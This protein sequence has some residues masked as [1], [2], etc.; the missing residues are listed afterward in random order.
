[1]PAALR[2]LLIVL[3]TLVV[4]CGI[5]WAAVAILLPPS[6]VRAL[7]EQQANA[8]L[9]RPFRLD[10]VSVG[11]WPPVRASLRG[12]A[13]AEPGGFAS[14]AAFQ[15]EAIHVDVDLFALIAKRVVVRRLTLE[16][17]AIH[18]VLRADGATNFDSL[19]KAP[20]PATGGAGGA[21]P[22]PAMDLAVDR[23]GIHGGQLLV[24]DLK[25]KRRTALDIESTQHLSL[26]SN[27][28]RIG[29]GG[30][31]ALSGLAFG[32]LTAARRSD[33]NQ[34]LAA[35][36]W[37]I[38]HQGAY[39]A[40][41]QRLALERLALA[42]GGT[43][44]EMKGVVDHPGP[45]ATL[46]LTSQG[47]GVDLAE[48]LKMLATADASALH[49]ISGAGRLDF[50][51]RV[52][53]GL[54]PDRLPALTGVLHLKDASFRYPGAP[55]GVDALA[56]TANF[57]PDSLGIG[58]L[59]CRVAQQPVRAQLEVTHFADP[60]VRFAVQG[61]LDLAAI[62]PL[63]GQNDATL[64]G[65]VAVD[66]RGRGRAKDA[67]A[68]ALEGTAKLA[69]VSVEA[70]PLPKK[71]EG[72]NGDLAFSMDKVAVKALTL[73]AGQSSLALDAT[74]TRPLALMAKPGSTPPAG[75]QFSLRSPY[76]DL[77]E[78]M[79]AGGGGPVLP[80]AKGGGTIRIAQLKNQKLDV[81]NVSADIALEPGVMSAPAFGLDGYG[82]AVR[83][84]ARFD[85]R[86]PAAPVYAL[87][88]KIDTVRA[89]QILAAWTPLKG[90]IKA[91]LNT[92][93]DL[94]GAGT[95]PDQI[96]RTL[97]AIGAAAMANGT[98]GPGPALEAIA[99][100]VKMPELKEVR[101]S[102]LKLPFRIERGRMI[103]N[104]AKLVGPYGE[105]NAAGSAGFDGTLDYAV[106]ITLPPDVVQKLNAKS[107]QAAGAL[108]DD[109]GRML[110]DLKVG[111]TATSPRVEWDTK[112]MQDRLAGRASAALAE[113][114]AKIEQD[115]KKN[116]TPENLA[117]PDSLKRIVDQYKGISH[118]S[119]KKVGTDLIN[120]FFGKKPAK[121]DTTKRDT[122]RK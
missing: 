88:A 97:T 65:R 74:V 84:S 17:P 105:W 120:S 70:K 71:I 44:I 53:G 117:S 36:T 122:M 93:L 89:E 83:G 103:T 94:S 106:S 75:M 77:A 108:A 79:P 12:V 38:E 119:L 82:G 34:G 67:T 91:S 37:N 61:N 24:D 98:I 19:M 121:T 86:D 45:H 64:G 23:I 60:D 22:P 50:D 114:R 43:A 13:L 46:D 33:L 52:K 16:K 10:G 109:Q 66:V 78:L 5:A 62:A 25:A 111:G 118:D 47:T 59:A 41:R 115:L 68:M 6:R 110:L 31:T 99:A 28:Q 32:P 7:V 102:D 1:M 15:A 116:F 104:G 69:N 56:L 49:G 96:Q 100:L 73:K 11:L 26:Q 27:G 30:T 107:A 113:Q 87:K 92:S 29:T 80:N 95:Q 3:V 63:L 85:F 20:P 55:A 72:I 35:I 4:L 101:F 76:L 81:K 48:V 51:L 58:D 8:A 112:A 14:G 40:A 57:A 42:F 21:S 2:W 39:D 9:N 54:G 90:L 18:L